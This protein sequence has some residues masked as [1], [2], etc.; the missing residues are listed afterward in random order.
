MMRRLLHTSWISLLALVLLVAGA[1][2]YVGW[3]SAGLQR[4]VALSSRRLGP[5]TL[6]ISGARGTLHGGVHIDRLV[7]DHERVHIVARG[8]DGRIALLPLLWQTIRV[9][10]LN[11]DTLQIHVLPYRARGGPPW[12]PH[13]LVGLLNIQ[14]EKVTAAHAE[15]V[16]PSGFSL[17]ADQ[18]RATGQVGAREIR[19]FDSSL[20][21]A[22]FEVRSAGSVLAAR[23]IGLR[24]ETRLSLSAPG[25]P[26]WLA[27]AQFEGN[28]DLL[29]ISGVVLAPFNADFHGDAR[30]LSGAWHWQGRSQ[31]RDLDLRAW[32]LGGALGRI[33]GTLQLG[34][35]RGGF[36]AQGALEAPGLKAGPLAVDFAGSYAARV[37]QI[38]HLTLGHRASAARLSANGQV[39]IL[40]GGP[41]LELSGQWQDLRWPLAAA[42]AAAPLQ[43]AAGNF[44]LRGLRPYAFETAGA[45]QLP[46]LP[47]LQFRGAGRLA[48]DGLDLA[49]AAL[50]LGSGQARL[51][52][53]LR[54]S[55]GA[56]WSA[57]G[58]VRGL[59][60]ASLRPAV[61]GRLDFAVA[62][63]GQGF[64][65]NRTLQAQISA[66]SGNVRGQRASGQAAF[67]LEGGDWL[68]QQVRLQLGAT[69]LE[70]D[71]RIGAHPDL[72]FAVDATDLALLRNGARGR[73]QVAGR[74]RGDAHRPLL[75]ARLSGSELAFGT[76]R[77]RSVD[78]TIDF[79]PQGSG[80]A[81]ASLQLDGLS[82]GERS[83]EHLGFSTAGTAAAHQFALQLQAAP[84][85]VHAAGAAS[86]SDG[87]WR[88]ELGEFT[89]DDAAAIHLALAAPA[90]LVAALGGEELHLEHFCLRGG[91][92]QLCAALTRL[93]DHS[94][95]NLSASN[96][97]LRALTAGLS[98]A[99]DFDGQVSLAAQAEAT[100]AAAWTGTLQGTLSDAGLRHRLSGGRVE[101]FKLGNGSLQAALGAAGLNASLLLDA[102]AA[103]SITGR[104]TARNDGGAM[105]A[106]P[107]DGAL[108]LQTHALGFID[109]YV[110]Q[111]DRV[112]GQLDANLTLGGRLAAPALNGELKLTGAEV[113]AY[114][115]NL[116]LRELNFVARLN[117]PLLQLAGSAAAGAD[118]HAQFTGAIEWRDRLPYGEL[119]LSGEDLR[120]I[121]VPE[122]R[123]QAS[124]DVHM[125][126]A[127]RRIDVTGT[128]T[129]PYARL[130]RPDQLTNAVRAS[131][132]EVIVVPDRAPPREGF[133]VF[134]DLTLSLGERVTIDT[135]GLNGRLSGS[136][137][138]VTDD[139]GFSRGTG[140]LQVEEGKYTAFGR[141]LDIE[142]GRLQFR[143]G[144]LNDPAIDLRAVK[145][146]PDITAGVNVRGT[147]RAP[148]MTFFSDPPVSQ[149][150]VVSLLIAGGSL[151]SV[152]DTSDPAQRNN[153]AR[154]NMLLQGSALLFQ[155]FGGKVGLDDVSVESDLNNDTSLVLGRY[156]SPRLY[157]S[158]GISLAEAI[159]TIKMRY[160][161]G[162]HWTIKTEAGTARSADLVYTI[163]R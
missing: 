122:A 120:V 161:I 86:F 156:L 92:T 32:Q 47:S 2:Y 58:T 3:T 46:G 111:V 153:A 57:A 115:I 82:L 87:V 78:G 44:S 7:V 20:R 38:A 56:R 21:Y 83:L 135:F 72:Q 30:A 14:A 112:S 15:L 68:L 93:P 16:S 5:V 103:G 52:G 88:A 13:F 98:S 130:E 28:L 97:P 106:W 131:S 157:V 71:G 17:A 54:W 162:D 65:A 85:T 155:Q 150:Q 59:N 148:R 121:N 60:I 127:G 36:H 23:P 147:L 70:A 77:L 100:G 134:S 9:A 118:G 31:V 19:V 117:G 143:N 152:Q 75:R 1:I 24:G 55:P 12:R 63:A 141:K 42:A 128:V 80:H 163:E 126:F 40:E 140:E 129:L 114:Q 8:V 160:T 84:F 37:L 41:R 158:Y 74:F 11:I 107:M 132:D 76:A 90:A 108:Q 25:R 62:A 66:I 91:Q 124:P 49:D 96:V 27:N 94:E 6:A 43:S 53:E 61:R 139:T 79:D 146:F 151:E 125:K 51:H 145:K 101:A 39:G 95:L 105:G 142:R 26:A 137:R 50:T 144:P 133:R 64:G 138:A 69:R 113:D 110:A 159:N 154:N 48:H 99:T 45:L 104:I 33:G 29:A 119:H 67:A 35:D 89:A 22:G 34:G 116:A 102:G 81:D 18:L 10:Q 73:L 123:V 149:A 109:S 136:L 4:L